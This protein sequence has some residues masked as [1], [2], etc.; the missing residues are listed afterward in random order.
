M[1]ERINISAPHIDVDAAIVDIK[2]VLE[3]GMMAQGPRVALA[4]KAMAA[5]FGARYGIAYSNGTSSLRGALIAGLAAREGVGAAEVDRFIDGKQVIIPAFSFNATLNSV[6]G[7]GGTARVVDITESD[8]GID[9]RRAESV[10]GSD[11]AAI[12]PVDLYGQAAD[13]STEDNAFRGLTIIRDAAQAH[14]ATLRGRPIVEHG[15]ATS[16]SFYPT[17]NVAG[18]GEGGGIL[19]ND[20]NIDKVARWYRNQGMSAPY[21]YEMIGEN[22]RMTDIQAVILELSL[23]GMVAA[24]ARRRAN[25]ALLSEGLAAVPGITLP[26]THE[27][28]E[29]VW[30]QYTVTVDP[31]EFGMTRDDLRTRLDA[32]GIGCGIYYPKTMTNHPSYRDHPRII[33][34]PTPVADEVAQRVLSLPVHPKVSPMDIERIVGTIEKIQ[35][36]EL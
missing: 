2:K 13:I 22:A 9:R 3:S 23:G 16:T 15:H 26:Q 30:H 12:M 18:G 17:K 1:P 33:K 21:V 32:H 10:T 6:V 24:N 7:A 36:G 5:A 8:Y 20:P 14:G 31:D 11:T 35:R 34:D 19:T 28:R 27:G 29:H 25:A 4:E